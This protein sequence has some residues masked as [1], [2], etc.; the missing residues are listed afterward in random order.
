MA[1]PGNN[2]GNLRINLKTADY[3][4]DRQA[5]HVAGQVRAAYAVAVVS[6]AP[7]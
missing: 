4:L 7:D 3:F 2:V 1:V 5:P 6:S